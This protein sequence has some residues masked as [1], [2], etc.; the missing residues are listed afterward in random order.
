MDYDW[1]AGGV[2]NTKNELANPAAQFSLFSLARDITGPILFVTS[3]RPRVSPLVK[4]S[5]WDHFENNGNSGIN[6][7][8]DQQEQYQVDFEED[9]AGQQGLNACPART[10]VSFH[11]IPCR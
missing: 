1:R 8:V 10:V 4:I 11:H 5:S 9:Q 2:S 6:V 3:L 7:L